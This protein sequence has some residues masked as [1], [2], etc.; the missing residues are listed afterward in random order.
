CLGLFDT[1]ADALCQV[2]S[3]SVVPDLIA[4]AQ[5]MEWV[6]PLQDLLNEIRNDV[7][8]GQ[9]DVAAHDLFFAE[10]PPFADA[11]AIKGPDD[12]IGELI[13]LPGALGVVFS[14]KLLKA[15]RGAGRRAAPL[16]AFFG[17]PALGVLED[18]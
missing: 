1:D 18:H 9:P 4:V 7:A 5:D 16:F 10:G 8:H 13:L 6:L 2:G 12:R 17:R 14:G 15:V 11:D 3:I